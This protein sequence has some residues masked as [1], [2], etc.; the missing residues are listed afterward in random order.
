[1]CSFPVPHHQG[2]GKGM[3]KVRKKSTKWGTNLFS[4]VLPGKFF[5]SGK[6]GGN[7]EKTTALKTPKAAK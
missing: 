7:G 2:Q 1:M 6:W 4:F 5:S 3:L